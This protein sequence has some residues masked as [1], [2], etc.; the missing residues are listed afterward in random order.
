MKQENKEKGKKKA[1]SNVT[2]RNKP[3]SAK[4]TGTKKAADSKEELEEK[5]RVE[6][7][8]AIDGERCNADNKL[9]RSRKYPYPPPLPQKGL[10]FPGG[11]GFCKT[12]KCKEMYEA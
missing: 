3:A 12:K 2:T 1:Q 9:C 6:Q 10:E 8:K 11:W 4:D 5:E 7:E